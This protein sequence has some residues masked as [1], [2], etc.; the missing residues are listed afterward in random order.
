M[1][2][3]AV[4]FD[5]LN[6]QETLAVVNASVDSDNI[7]AEF[8]MVVRSDLQGLGL[9]KILLKKIIQYQKAKGTAYLTGMT[10][11]SNVGMASLSKKLGFELERDM[12]EGVIYMKLALQKPS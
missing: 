12:Q 9:G 8:A 4:R 7:D 1:A 2:F 11:L 10:M 5:E 6:E 3:V